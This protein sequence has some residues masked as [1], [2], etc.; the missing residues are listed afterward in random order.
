MNYSNKKIV[1]LLRVSLRESDLRHAGDHLEALIATM[2]FGINELSLFQR[3]FLLYTS[4]GPKDSDLRKKFDI[5]RVIIT[6]HMNAKIFEILNGLNSFKLNA[7]KEISQNSKLG[8][9][10]PVIKLLNKHLKG[11]AVL[12]NRHGFK[13]SED[14]RN[15]VTFHTRADNT[16]KSREHVPKATDFTFYLHSSLGDS[17]Y[18]IGEDFVFGACIS[19][20][21][22]T[23]KQTEVE[24]IEQWMDW[25]LQASRIIVIA[26]ESLMTDLVRDGLIKATARDVSYYLEPDFTHSDSGKH[27][28]LFLTEKL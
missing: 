23:Y 10:D 4:D 17:F 7:V 27:V 12:R 2:C 24:T 6:R 18:P 20:I 21:S 22:E 15:K 5:E 19:E 8:R 14:I 16:K 1:H 26:F 9:S 25:S 3:L 13:V 28:P 11:I